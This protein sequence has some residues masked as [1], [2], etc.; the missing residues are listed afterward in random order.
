M[1][2]QTAADVYLEEAD[3]LLEKGDVVQ[4]S[5]KYYKAAEE[6]VKLLALSRNLGIV[7]EVERKGKWS[8]DD[9]QEAVRELEKEMGGIEDLWKSAIVVLST[10]LQP[11]ILEKEVRKVKELVRISDGAY[12]LPD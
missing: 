12:T 2:V 4:A 8:L 11:H 5:E 10:T 9:L 7:K 6:A 1:I 3:G